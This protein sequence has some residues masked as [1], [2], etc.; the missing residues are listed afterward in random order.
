MADLL[1]PT[2]MAHIVDDGVKQADA[3]Q[4]FH[5][6]AVDTVTEKRIRDAMLSITQGRTSFVIVYRLST[7]RD[8]D[9]IILL[10]NGRI[11]EQGNHEKLMARNGKY[12]AMYRTQM[13]A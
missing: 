4:I 11:A 3:A 7:I 8:S 9:L 6:G 2:F 10:E 5:Y 1:Q 12:A 13:G